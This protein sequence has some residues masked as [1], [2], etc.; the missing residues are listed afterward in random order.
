MPRKVTVTEVMSRARPWCLKY[1]DDKN[2]SF[3]VERQTTLIR[4]RRVMAIRHAHC[5][6]DQLGRKMSRGASLQAN[7]P[8]SLRSRPHCIMSVIAL[9]GTR[10][11]EYDRAFYICSCISAIVTV[12]EVI[13]EIQ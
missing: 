12:E 8:A 5:R 2:F 13:D 3:S 4:C 10:T 1:T 7:P 9:F 6:R 11:T